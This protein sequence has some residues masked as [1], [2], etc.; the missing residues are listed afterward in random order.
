MRWYFEPRREQQPDDDEEASLG[1]ASFP[2]ALLQRHGAAVLDPAQAAVVYGWPVPQSTV[3]RTR[4]LLVPPE[5]LQDEQVSRVIKNVLGEIGLDLA[6]PERASTGDLRP[7][8]PVTVVLV[9]RA[10][11]DEMAARP[12]VVDAWTALQ[13]LRAAALS[14]QHAGLTVEAVDQIGLEH[15]LIGSAITGSPASEGGGVSGSPASEGGGV[16]GPA[17]TD[18]YLLGGWDARIPV[19]VFMH[20]PPRESQGRCAERF[21]RRPVVAV[22]D[23]GI[24]EHWW[25]DVH[26]DPAAPGG[27]GTDPDGFAAVDLAMQDLIYAH[28]Q[29]ASAAGDRPRHLIRYPWDRP[30]TANELIGEL[31]TDTGHGTFIAGIMRQWVPDAQV[32]AIRIMHSDGI[33]Y[34][35]DLLYALGLLAS[36]VAAAQNGDMALMVDLVSLSLGYFSETGADRA[37]TF[38]LWRA[39]EPLLETGVAVIAAAGNFSTTRR[40]YPAAFADLTGP[41]GIP[42]ISVGA[43]NPNG[44]KALFSNDGR[45]V[46]AWATGA[47]V[48]STFPTDV[49]GS[50]D[51]DVSLPAVVP[52]GVPVP[53]ERAALDPDDFSGGFSMWSGTSF[54]G[55]AIAGVVAAELLEG[56]ESGGGLSLAS[57][58]ADAA[59]SRIGHALANLGWAG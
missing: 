27:Y 30:L 4:T 53:A 12:V 51:P 37:Y 54:S 14:P 43:L 55:P 22:L 40:F 17:S 24:R 13:T 33:V 6:V 20:A 29:L 21:G 50:R 39:I 38:A 15:L 46:R 8:L 5:L 26:K 57:S 19:E 58:G 31:D 28:G 1:L 59:V 34:E 56:A 9:P 23:T 7:G 47:A 52:P 2:A 11:A 49:D 42:V 41:G 32:L 18:S 25:L 45:W 3:Y 36:R 44:S 35:G 48:V 10:P 16:T